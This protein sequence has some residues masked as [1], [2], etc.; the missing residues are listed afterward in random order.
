MKGVELMTRPEETEEKGEAMRL[1][2][3]TEHDKNIK[4]RT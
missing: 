4:C 2:R 1:D 3:K